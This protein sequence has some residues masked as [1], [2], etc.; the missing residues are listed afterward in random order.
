MIL[1]TYEQWLNCIQV[2]C[3]IQLTPQFVEERLQTLSDQSQAETKKF[4][5][6]HGEEHY[7]KIINWYKRTKE[8]QR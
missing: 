7:E 5:A 6:T 8:N 1:E 2:D 3:G 4:V